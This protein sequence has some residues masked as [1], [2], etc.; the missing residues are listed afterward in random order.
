[1]G[2]SYHSNDARGVLMQL[3]PNTGAA[4]MRARALVPVDG[5][6]LGGNW[7]TKDKHWAS[8]AAIWRMRVHSEL[9]FTGD[10]GTTEE[11]G[12]ASERTGFEG[13]LT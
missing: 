11:A 3:D 10:A 6:E 4:V 7:Q 13:T 5:V 1:M 9:V 8:S 12:V 2:R